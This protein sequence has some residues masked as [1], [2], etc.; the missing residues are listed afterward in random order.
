[1][2]KSF[3]T[4]NVIERVNEEFRRRVKTQGSFSTEA[5][6]LVLLYGLIASGTIRMRKIDGYPALADMVARA[7]K[8][9]A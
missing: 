1:M 7:E 9:I 6:A 4:T 2:C 8:K 3:L 5:S